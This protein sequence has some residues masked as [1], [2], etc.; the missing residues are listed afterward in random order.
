MV[1]PIITNTNRGNNILNKSQNNS[2]SKGNEIK[3]DK[4]FN[5]NPNIIDTITIM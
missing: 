1:I 3:E 4:I 2:I 5:D